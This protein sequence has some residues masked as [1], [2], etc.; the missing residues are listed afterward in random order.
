MLRRRRLSDFDGAGGA[1]TTRCGSAARE[2]DWVLECHPDSVPFDAAL[3]RG[4]SGP[5]RHH[6][7]GSQSS[8]MRR[9]AE[10]RGTVTPDA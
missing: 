6:R 8:G 4:T 3:L 7:V 9:M 5:R 1:S 2:H 10:W